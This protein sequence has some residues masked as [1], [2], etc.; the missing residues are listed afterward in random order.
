MRTNTLRTLR[1]ETDFWHCASKHKYLQEHV[2]FPNLF[3]TQG[4]KK[5][6]EFASLQKTKARLLLGNYKGYMICLGKTIPKFELLGLNKIPYI[7]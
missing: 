3:L 4:K 2:N 6:W 1:V 5:L 7:D